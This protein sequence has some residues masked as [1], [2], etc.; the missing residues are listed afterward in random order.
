[1]LPDF[2]TMCQARLGEPTDPNVASGVRHH[3]R[4]DAAFH[5][6]R[7]F[8]DLY[9]EGERLL[10][11]AGAARGPARGG[12]HVAVELFLDGALVRDPAI[13]EIYLEALAAGAPRH[14]TVELD[15]WEAL[16]GRLVSRGVPHGYRDPALVAEITAHILSRRPLLAC[17][18]D[19][20][21]A[22]DRALPRLA[23]QVS[24][25]VPSILD[26]LRQRLPP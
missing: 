16:H 3:H 13:A 4:A 22:L 1:M 7:A 10:G 12:A 24:A 23:G 15:G 11:A 19:D 9:R 20:E 2:A 6:L 21:R 18:P 26:Q 5:R 17:S 14:G 8:L 25:A